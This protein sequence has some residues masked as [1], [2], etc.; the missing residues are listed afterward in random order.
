MTT[1]TVQ[2]TRA[3]RGPGCS[4]QAL[5]KAHI[6]PAGFARIMH[7][8]GGHNLG[9]SD[10][11]ARRAQYQLGAFDKG[12]LCGPCDKRLGKLD[13]FALTFC[14]AERPTPSAGTIA[15]IVGVDGGQLLAFATSVVWRASISTLETFAGI[16]LGPLTDRARDIAFGEPA[17]VFPVIANRL[18]SARYDVREFYVQPIRRKLAGLNAYSFLLGGFQWFV[19]ADSRSLPSNLRRLVIPG[20]TDFAS[21]A[22]PLEGTPEFRDLLAIADRHR[23]R[24]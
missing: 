9:V 2:R 21:L 20:A 1:R 17:V 23:R 15:Q 10:A 14:T 3:C 7:R 8:E 16:D 12:I 4:S 18:V 5:I 6:M 11:G 24:V 22:V 13:A 19:V